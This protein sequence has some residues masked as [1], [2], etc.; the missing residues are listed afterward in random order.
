M[1]TVAE[2][3]AFAAYTEAKRHQ[4]LAFDAFQKVYEG[5]VTAQDWDEV[6]ERSKDWN[7]A[8]REVDTAF[9]RYMEATRS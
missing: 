9:G 5:A 8:R 1:M 4:A 6:Q 2:R 3:S 7:D